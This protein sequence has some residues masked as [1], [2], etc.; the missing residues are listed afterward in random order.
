MRRVIPLTAIGVAVASGV[1]IF[2]FTRPSSEAR[3]SYRA[4]EQAS[5]VEAVGDK[6]KC[7]QACKAGTS[8]P[9]CRAIPL[10]AQYKSGLRNLGNRLSSGATVVRKAALMAD[11]GA[12]S[13]PC[14]RSDTSLQQGRWTNR[15]ES[16]LMS[17][18]IDVFGDGRPVKF[19]LAVPPEIAFVATASQQGRHYRSGSGAIT[20]R[21]HDEG[22]HNDWG[23]SLAE[24]I[25]GP[26]GVLL[27]M[28]R[29][30]IKLGDK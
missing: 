11:F 26:N 9:Y 27:Q 16:C 2:A 3:V 10:N 20:L 12:Q 7:A 23:G 14:N 17:A 8:T 19:E 4:D 22:L 5:F 21:I 28:P 6:Y 30:C 25:D 1:A 13:D 18:D 15:G 29:G 24:V